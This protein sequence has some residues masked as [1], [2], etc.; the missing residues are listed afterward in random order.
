MILYHVFLQCAM[1]DPYSVLFWGPRSPMLNVPMWCRQIWAFEL[2]SK[3][4][5]KY[6]VSFGLTSRTQSPIRFLTVFSFLSFKQVSQE[7][8]GVTHLIPKVR[9]F[10][11]KPASGVGA[12]KVP[13]KA[14]APVRFSIKNWNGWWARR[15]A[16][17]SIDKFNLYRHLK[18]GESVPPPPL[19]LNKRIW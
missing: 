1:L 15:S 2:S 17:L 6:C 8:S 13:Q 12:K 10:P 16:A 4:R 14:L 11:L 5:K 9:F 7:K 3:E 18:P 19:L